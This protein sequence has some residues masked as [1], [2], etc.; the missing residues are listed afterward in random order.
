MSLWESLTTIYCM[1]LHQYMR[2]DIIVLALAVYKEFFL[3]ELPQAYV[4]SFL[5]HLSNVEK[6]RM[7][8]RL[9]CYCTQIADCS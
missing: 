7:E 1:E 2:G 6:F 9:F 8:F 3:S 4:Q 5:F